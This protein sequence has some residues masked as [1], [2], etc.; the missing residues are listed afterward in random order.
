VLV[1]AAV[2]G[3]A[4][5]LGFAI[6]KTITGASVSAAAGDLGGQI[7]INLPGAEVLTSAESLSASISEVITFPGASVSALAGVI[8]VAGVAT[9]VPIFGAEV[10]AVAGDINARAGT[11]A[12]LGA[13]VT[14]FAG[15]VFRI[16]LQINPN[17]DLG[18]TAGRS[19]TLVAPSGRLAL[20]APPRRNL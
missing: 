18:K 6:S 19:F 7:T 14:T 11:I 5:S 2:S 1:G 3:V 16:S 9:V 4:G 12:L 15:T 20:I 10:V 13:E 8:G 17:L